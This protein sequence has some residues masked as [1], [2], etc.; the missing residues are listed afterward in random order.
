[1]PWN[2]AVQPSRF[3]SPSH[4]SQR[5]PMDGSPEPGPSVSWSSHGDSWRC[6]DG[7]LAARTRSGRSP[8]NSSST[9]PR[10]EKS[11]TCLTACQTP[12]SSDPNGGNADGNRSDADKYRKHRLYAALREPRHAD[13]AWAR[14]FLWRSGAAQERADHHDAKLHVAGMDDGLVVCLRL[15]GEFWA[16]L[17]RHHWESRNVCIPARRNAANDVCQHRE[18]PA[19]RAHRLSDDVRHHHARA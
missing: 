1:M 10:R 5:R 18:H 11:A 2:R 4:V 14:L 9:S 19:H 12:F 8:R 16:R 6:G 15:L 17:A 3:S 7:T 13:D